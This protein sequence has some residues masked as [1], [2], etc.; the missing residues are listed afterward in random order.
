[1]SLFQ[2]IGAYVDVLLPLPL[3][4]AFTYAVSPA[5]VEEIQIGKRVVVPFQ[6]G[7]FYSGLII[8]IHAENPTSYPCKMVEEVLDVFPLLE[9][10]HL[11]F[12]KWMSQ[13]YLS[14]LGLVMNQAFPSALKLASKTILLPNPDFDAETEM[15][16]SDQEF[17]LLEAIQIRGKID[18]DEA[19]KIIRKRSAFGV[20]RSLIQ[21]GGAMATE[22]INEKVAPKF[23]NVL[24]LHPN[25]REEPQLRILFDVLEKA[26][27]QLDALLVF[28]QMSK[29]STFEVSRKEFLKHPKV[30]VQ[31]ISAL[32]QKGILQQSKQ[33]VSRLLESAVERKEIILSSAQSQALAEI[34][35]GFSR[36]ATVL[37]RGIT[38]SGK[39]AIYI[40]LIEEQLK[41]GK[42]VL[43]L[44]PEI[45]LTTQLV[46][47][48]RQ[49]FGEVGVYHSKM[50]EQERVELFNA[51]VQN[52]FQLVLGVRSGVFLP[53]SN[54]GLIIVDE[55]HDTAYK[56]AEP[57]PRFH[58][59]DSAMVL[60]QLQNAQVLLGSATPSIE[61][62]FAAQSGKIGLVELDER[63]GE[64]VPPAI[65][66]IDMVKA[67][68]QGAIKEY[69]SFALLSEIQEKVEN[70]DQVILFRNRRGYHP[71]QQCST[72]GK[73]VECPNCDVSLNYHKG[74]Q[75]LV[76]HYCGHHEKSVSSCKSCG[77]EEISMLGFGTE[78]VEEDVQALFPDY[79]IERLD[80]DVTKKKSAF[81]DIFK[82]MEEGEID[83][84]VGTQ[85]ISKG[86]DFENVTLVGV[87]NADQSL[88]WTDFRAVE[89]TFQQL[90][91]VS[92]RAGRHLKKGKVL[93]QTRQPQHPMFSFLK[94]QDYPSFFHWQIKERKEFGYPPF[95]KM[96]VIT[97][98]GKKEEIVDEAAQL[99]AKKLRIS[100][101]K[102]TLGPVPP[103]VS[104][105][106]NRYYR[107]IQVKYQVEKIKPQTIKAHLH[108]LQKALQGAPIFKSIF[109]SIDV[110]PA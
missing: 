88:S 82:A 26:P 38:G 68:E 62:Y 22:E 28:L 89:R 7:K 9:E 58:A 56:Q 30:Q 34:K 63:F 10:K 45:A 73:L 92:G 49:V 87:L 95:S 66:L 96:M 101:P 107:Q 99:M 3:E 70:N 35:T 103:P 16:L 104:K 2:E 81:K 29:N 37:F 1:M 57:S 93:I 74:S 60:A 12:W 32:I 69:F 42:Q 54:L 40:K 14:P 80:Q 24:S 15:E 76:C 23:E 86:L 43:F 20:V 33:R 36:F 41:Q 106:N 84:L 17:M 110:D 11:Q 72:C 61:S 75:N 78:K 77:S 13:Y 59:R 5:L 109:I 98:S 97:L 51:V 19:A 46:G 64:A 105:I 85:M 53:F 55:E 6:K 108:D 18:L 91:Q 25:F 71:V 94:K 44:V 67:K 31:P 39:T 4:N 90:M 79:K 47:R 48:I 8:N 50:N 100:L 83:I 65:E 27:K 52:Q 21:K 102:G